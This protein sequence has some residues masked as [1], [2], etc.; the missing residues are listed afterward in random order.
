[1]ANI[2][3]A[4]TSGITKT[5]TAIPD[6]PDAPTIGTATAGNAAAT[7]TYT[8]STTGGAVTT[9]T[10]TS[11]P[12][13]VTGT[14]ASPIT[15]S[16]LTNGTAYTFTVSGANS[17]GTSPASSASNSVTP[18]NP[19]FVYWTRSP[20]GDSTL[21]KFDTNTE[22]TAV[23]P[24]TTIS[25]YQS[26]S[27]SNTPTAGYFATGTP[28]GGTD[29]AR[30]SV[31]KL[32][33]ATDSSSVAISSGA[34]TRLQVT[35]FSNVGT[36]GYYTGGEYFSQ[37]SNTGKI[38]YSN[39]TFSDI[40]KNI[41][42]SNGRSAM[43]SNKGSAAYLGHG[44]ANSA[45]Q[46]FTF[47]NETYSTIGNSGY[48]PYHPAGLS[49][50]GTAG[51][52]TGGTGSSGIGQNVRKITFSNDTISTTSGLV[53]VRYTHSGSGIKGS[54]GFISGGGQSPTNGSSIIEKIT[55]STDTWSE[56]GARIAGSGDRQF[57]TSVANEGS[58]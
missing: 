6:V 4:N 11:S 9:F 3:R 49:N 30:S 47:S 27:T 31:D 7:I 44:S 29:Q 54:S 41:S 10:A 32:A 12:G 35:G 28:T 8:A 15:V 58:I 22:T 51:Y 34:F 39:D 17:T 21:D 24:T 1:M 18:I 2:K 40:S 19:T 56:L 33:F 38:T 45:I 57:T 26:A 14:G 5:G 46:K 53:Y 25:R 16:G 48:A 20:S 50:S 36:A 42:I 55:F 52:M 23:G 37:F 13:S 43:M